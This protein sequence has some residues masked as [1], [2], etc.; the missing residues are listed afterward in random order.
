MTDCS[1]CFESLDEK[2]NIAITDCG[3]KFHLSC[4]KHWTKDTCPMCRNKD[5]KKNDK[6]LVYEMVKCLSV[7]DDSK[8][9]KT[10]L[11]LYM[12]N[13]LQN[14]LDDI[15]PM[16]K[17]LIVYFIKLYIDNFSNDDDSDD[18]GGQTEYHHNYSVNYVLRHKL[19]P[20]L[21]YYDLSLPE[22]QTMLIE[23]DDVEFTKYINFDEN[24]LFTIVKNNCINLLK[25][26]KDK[27]DTTRLYSCKP[28]TI[29]LNR[30]NLLGVACIYGHLEIVQY[31]SEFFNVNEPNE[32][33]C[34]PLYAAIAS[35]ELKMV[36]WLVNQGIDVNVKH[37]CGSTPLYYAIERNYYNIAHYLINKGAIV[38]S[39]IIRACINFTED[40]RGGLKML[41]RVLKMIHPIDLYKPSI[42]FCH[43]SHNEHKDLLYCEC[44]DGKTCCFCV[45]CRLKDDLCPGKAWTFIQG[46]CHRKKFYSILLLLSY[47]YNLVNQKQEVCIHLEKHWENQKYVEYHS[48]HPH[49]KFEKLKEYLFAF[50]EIPENHTC[51]Y[52]WEC[53]FGCKYERIKH[54]KI[55]AEHVYKLIQKGDT[56][57]KV[58]DTKVSWKHQKKILDKIVKQYNLQKYI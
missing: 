39:K 28:D 12:S 53:S 4:Y 37:V 50:K 13:Y 38:D 3:H 2:K 18:D 48:K 35:G 8:I 31:L 1:I 57:T 56:D 21:P 27:I 10:T 34:T 58:S 16:Y 24:T 22:T 41:Q 7:D 45:E 49:Y 32:W 20:L 54:F 36:K 44:H 43:N 51:G 40:S 29:A 5:A 6:L 25:N 33:N 14:N 46:A 19:Y 23:K 55:V 30:F 15:Q 52:S 42:Q 9:N 17:G 47:D 26:Y 11:L